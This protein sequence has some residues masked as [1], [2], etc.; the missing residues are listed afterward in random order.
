MG[1]E[2]LA[3]ASGDLSSSPGSSACDNAL[4]PL[5]LVLE[6]LPFTIC[7]IYKY[8]VH[9]RKDDKTDLA[10]TKGQGPVVVR[11]EGRN[12]QVHSLSPSSCSLRHMIDTGCM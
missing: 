1:E 2:A 4:T 7:R 3:E 10:L 5:P 8:E 11:G 12:D 9:K 6:L